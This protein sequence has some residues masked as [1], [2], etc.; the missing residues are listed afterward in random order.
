MRTRARSHRANFLNRL[1]ALVAFVT[2]PAALAIVGL[3]IYAGISR[4]LTALAALLLA[5]L[6]GYCLATIRTRVSFQFMTISVLLDGLEIGDYSLRGRRHRSDDSLD[7][8]VV[9]INRLA[10]ELARQRSSIKEGRLLLEK[11]IRQIGVAILAFNDR[12]EVVLANPAAV[13]LYGF[14][15]EEIL[16]SNVASLDAKAMLAADDD[17]VVDLEFPNRSG[18]FHIRLD[19]FREQARVHRLVFLTDVQVL[20]RSEERRAWQD[21]IRVISHEINNS[22]A[23]ISSISKTLREGAMDGGVASSGRSGLADGLKVIEERSIALKSFVQRFGQ[24]SQLPEPD[25]ELV[26]IRQLVESVTPLFDKREVVC[27]SN[28]E[29]VLQADPVQ[30][31]QVLINLF[32]NADEA[33]SDSAG[34]I[35]IDWV[36]KNQRVLIKI[37]DE[38]SGIGNP[39]NLFVPLYTTK[40]HGSGLGLALCRQ[41]VEAHDGNLAISNRADARGCEVTIE[42]PA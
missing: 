21:L 5:L 22:L 6:V 20:L 41:V 42:L 23:P 31:K 4:Y 1:V 14:S 3:M 33:M 7:G 24:L 17:S 25:K 18:R 13:A 9:Q 2:V 27:K 35:T 16:K 38:G 26:S 32:K 36:K 37:T 11:V 28:L 29:T 8:V 30:L 10:K 39:D 12:D 15:S 19:E 34:V 40:E